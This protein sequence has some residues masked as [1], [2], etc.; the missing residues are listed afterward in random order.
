MPGVTAETDDGVLINVTATG[1]ND[2]VGVLIELHNYG[3]SGDALVNGTVPWFTVKAGNTQAPAR[4]VEFLDTATL[5][6]V[7]YSFTDTMTAVSSSGTT[8]TVTS[9]E[10]NIDTGWLYVVSGT[11]LGQLEFMAQSSSGSAVTA[12]AFGTALDTTSLMIKIL[13]LYHQL[14]KYDIA[15]ATVETKLGTDAAVGS[16]RFN[17]ILNH[18]VRNGLDEILNPSQHDNLTGLNTLASVGFYALGCFANSQF[19]QYD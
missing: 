13:P 5:V 1:V 3:A 11:G 9:L 6:R 17:I 12:T 15:T 2:L 4:D 16:G 18:I 10:D 7:P 19:H 8:V 14:V